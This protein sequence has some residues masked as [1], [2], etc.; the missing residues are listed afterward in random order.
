MRQ[1]RDDLDAVGARGWCGLGREF[2]AHQPIRRSGDLLSSPSGVWSKAPTARRSFLWR[3]KTHRTVREISTYWS[4][5]CTV[6]QRWVAATSSDG[7]PLA[8]RPTG[9]KSYGILNLRG[10]DLRKW[11]S[12]EC[13]RYVS[14]FAWELLKGLV[15]EWAAATKYC[16]AEGVGARALQSP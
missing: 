13:L 7:D 1:R 2:A 16:G 6:A 4:F 5:G 10:P 11:R 3:N 12:P 15:V 14:D 9:E 8:R